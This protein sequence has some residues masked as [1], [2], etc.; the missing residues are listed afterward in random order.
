MATTVQQVFDLSMALIDE[1]LDN[2][3]ISVSDTASYSAKTPSIVTLLQT[4]LIKTG[5]LFSTYEISNKPV[6]NLLGYSSEFDIMEFTGDEITREA[7]GSVKAYYFEVDRVGT[8]YVEDYNGSWN[9]LDTVTTTN[10]PSGFTAY[11]GVVTPS[12][13]AT[14]SRLRFTGTYYYRTV[15]R[16]LFSVPFESESDV[17]NYRPWVKVSMPADFKGISEIVEEYSD[18]QY[19]NTANF[20]WEGRKDLYMSYFYE[21]NIRIVYRPVPTIITAL[22][23]TL[24]IDDVTAR[25]V[26]PYGLAAHL[27]IEEN[28]TTASFFNQRYEELKSL[29]NRKPPA[30]IEEIQ[31][32]YGGF[33]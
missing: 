31:N 15:N 26:L 30:A 27:M 32:F 24:Q 20:K 10:T 19:F 13:G 29:A 5:D 2:G 7:E 33:G 28:T 3:T 9:T 1:V 21:G 12:D 6:D 8:V 22:T 11:K 23:D 16:A 17:P 14:R 4:E 25:T 18:R